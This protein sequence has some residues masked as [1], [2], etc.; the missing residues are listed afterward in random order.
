MLRSFDDPFFSILRYLRN[1]ASL[2]MFI[3]MYGLYTRYIER[4]EP[5][6]LSFLN[7]LKELGTGGLISMAA[8]GFMVALMAILGFYSVNEIGPVKNLTDSFFSQMMV[9]FTEELLFRLILFKLVEEFTGTWWALIVQGVLFGF[10]HIGNPNA[11]VWT[12]LGIVA[13]STLLLGG[14][15]ILTRRIWLVMGIHWSWN[16]FQAGVFGMP[17][18]GI[19]QP[20]LFHAVI[21]GPEWLTGGAWG[22]EASYVSIILNLLIGIYIMKLAIE[23]K[24][25]I[26]P[27]WKRN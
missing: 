5:Y 15:Y 13:D 26:T 11:T 6:E 27:M 21:T 2:I 23:K 24:Q 1:L 12:S 17:N 16:F 18:S 20:G 14:A 4:R 3:L 7:F 8:V 10:A 19:E 25:L 9:G 22:I